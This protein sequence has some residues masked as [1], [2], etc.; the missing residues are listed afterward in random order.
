MDQPRFVSPDSFCW[1]PECPAYGTV[2]Q[3][4]IRKFGRTR[5][6]TQ[7]DPCQ[8]CQHTFTETKGTIFHGRHHA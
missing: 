2:N 5:K 8:T 7:R 3:H 4:T 1:N 6:G